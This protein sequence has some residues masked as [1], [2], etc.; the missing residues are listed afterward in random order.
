MN[1]PF[2]TLLLILPVL[3]HRVTAIQKVEEISSRSKVKVISDDVIEVEGQCSC[4]CCDRDDLAR[5][6]NLQWYCVVSISLKR[7]V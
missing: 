3:M 1:I 6:Y 7:S 5:E 4:N 2:V